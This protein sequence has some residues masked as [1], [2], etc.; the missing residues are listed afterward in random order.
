[1]SAVCSENEPTLHT[2]GETHSLSPTVST[3]K[4]VD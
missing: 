3:M 4:S 2:N 1:M